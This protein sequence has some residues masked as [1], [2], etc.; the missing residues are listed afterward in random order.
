MQ[1]TLSMAEVPSLFL[2]SGT[3]FVEDSPS[4]DLGLVGGWFQD[5]SRTLYLLCTLFL[6][7]LRRLHLRSSG[8]RSKRLG[9]PGLCTFLALFN[10]PPPLFLAALCSLPILVP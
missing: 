2:G 6:L 8:I 3:G 10:F 1:V 7:L 4:M 9:T 5:D